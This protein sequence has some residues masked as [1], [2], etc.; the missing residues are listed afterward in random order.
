MPRIKA[1]TLR[2]LTHDGFRAAGY[3]GEEA[4][5]IAEPM[6]PA[7]LRGHDSHGVRQLPRYPQRIRE[8]RIVPTPTP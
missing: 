2:T 6:V 8:R 1:E 3:S 5:L 7:C 4:S